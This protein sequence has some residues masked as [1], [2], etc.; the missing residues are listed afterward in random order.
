MTEHWLLAGTFGAVITLGDK[1]LT[2]AV[3]RAGFCARIIPTAAP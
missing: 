3:Y 1:D 2:T